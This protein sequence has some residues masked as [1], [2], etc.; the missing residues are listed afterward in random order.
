MSKTKLIVQIPCYNE[1]E[2]LPL[3]V[4]SIPKSLPNIDII[5]TLI[6]DD[7]S[8]DDTVRIAQE[9]GVTHIVRHK[10]NSGLVAAFKSGID[11][12]LE[13]GADIIVNTDGDNQ[14]PQQ[15]IGRLIDPILEGTHDIVVGDRQV[16]KISHFSPLKK[17]LQKF[18]SKVVQIAADTEIVDAP[19]GFR[20]YSRKAALSMTL[21]TSFSYTLETLIQAG[22]KGLLVTYIPITTNPKTRES[23]LFKNIFEHV[24]KSIIT[25]LRVYTMYQPFKIF[26]TTGLAFFVIG[27]IPF[28]RVAYLMIKYQELISGHIQS[29]IVGT[30]LVIVGVLIMLIGIISDLLAINRKLLEETLQ[31]IKKVEYEKKER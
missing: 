12:C 7:G 24:F 2:T 1:E 28:L 16:S 22:K 26:F 18:G 10:K 3:V 21:V 30:V 31:R 23:R 15:D 11:A 8:T 6:I 20:A 9:L 4:G 17:F 27:A 25:I 29:L 19:S 13:N 14:Y 5:E